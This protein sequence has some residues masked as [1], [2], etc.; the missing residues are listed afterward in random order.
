MPPFENLEVK[1]FFFMVVLGIL[2]TLLQ[3]I[4]LGVGY[5]GPGAQNSGL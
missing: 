2:K 1:L 4:W 3:F 5:V